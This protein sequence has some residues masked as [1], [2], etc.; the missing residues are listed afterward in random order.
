MRS[1]VG[2]F[3]S[4]IYLVSWIFLGNFMLLNLFLAILLDSFTAPSEDAPQALTKEEEENPG[5]REQR[6]REV[7]IASLEKLQGDGLV[8]YYQIDK[9]SDA[10]KNSKQFNK[11]K[12]KKKKKAGA[13]GAPLLE[14]SF[15]LDKDV[16][17]K[18]ST[19]IK[20]KKKVYEGVDC[21]LSFYL[22]NKENCF[23]K[24]LY[25]ITSA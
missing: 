19:S 10:K 12:K 1:S 11:K 7:L 4:V 14:E 24:K 22:F 16:L 15:E 8:Q 5:L 18:K 13:E 21:E 3:L 25:T 23:R 17:A 6:E 20:P 2:I 9:S